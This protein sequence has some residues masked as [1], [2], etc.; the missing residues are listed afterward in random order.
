LRKIKRRTG[1]DGA[2]KREGKIKKERIE[3]VKTRD[4]R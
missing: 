2:T 4:A 1:A 3:T